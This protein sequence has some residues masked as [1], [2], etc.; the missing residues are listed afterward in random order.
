MDGP[1]RCEIGNE[2]CD[3][4]FLFPLDSDSAIDTY[5]TAVNSSLSREAV[6]LTR[7]A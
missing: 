7:G 1:T 6:E 5:I 4:Q 3:P 2:G